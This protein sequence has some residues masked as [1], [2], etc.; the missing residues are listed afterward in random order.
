MPEEETLVQH[1]R[2]VTAYGQLPIGAQE[3]FWDQSSAF[4][5]LCRRLFGL[6]CGFCQ[7]LENFYSK[8]PDDGVIE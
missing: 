2:K 8:K 1:L 5:A 4:V 7:G 6:D 3:G